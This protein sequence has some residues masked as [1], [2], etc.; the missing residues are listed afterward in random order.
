MSNNYFLIVI[1]EE[2]NIVEKIPA[3][4]QTDKELLRETK[5]RYEGQN[6]RFK[7]GNIVSEEQFQEVKALLEDIAQE[8][9]DMFQV[10]DK[11][12]PEF[13]HL[14]YEVNPKYAKRRRKR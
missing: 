4:H 13:R 12:R 7:F 1:D 8:Y 3:D 14:G 2:D 6:C 11:E 5:A 9:P 10:T